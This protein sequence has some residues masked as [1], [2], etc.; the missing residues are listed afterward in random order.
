MASDQEALRKLASAHD[1]EHVLDS[2][3]LRHFVK[4]SDHTERC[5]GHVHGRCDCGRQEL[6]DL[7]GDTEQE[8]DG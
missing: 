3:N 1:L 5:T 7:V 8:H 2:E 6:L 4:F